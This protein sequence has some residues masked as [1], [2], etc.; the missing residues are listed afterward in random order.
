MLVR[1]ENY[2]GFDSPVQILMNANWQMMSML[3]ILLVVSVPC[4]PHRI[5]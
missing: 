3:N 1:S 5:H 4:V 2:V